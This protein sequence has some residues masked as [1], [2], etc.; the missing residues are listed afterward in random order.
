MSSD[1]WST[2]TKFYD[3]TWA[4]PR[5]NTVLT[6][7]W[8]NNNVVTAMSAIAEFPNL[9][10]ELVRI[11]TKNTAGIYGFQ[12]YIRGQPWH[13][14]VDDKLLFKKNGASPILFHS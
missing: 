6:N 11:Q 13:V 9:M 7:T 2:A 10:G 3:T 5:T 1:K 14:V 4:T 12:L 8:R